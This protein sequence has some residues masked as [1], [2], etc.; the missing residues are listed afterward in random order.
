MESIA[1]NRPGRHIRTHWKPIRK[2]LSNLLESVY[3]NERK[4]SNKRALFRVHSE[5]SLDSIPHLLGIHLA[6]FI[7]P[8]NWSNGSHLKLAVSPK[9]NCLI[10]RRG[11]SRRNSFDSKFVTSDW[12]RL[13]QIGHFLLR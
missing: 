4:E 7:D 1:A 8:A 5:S 3:W 2:R 9:D 12:L 11:G 10:S 13:A 6:D